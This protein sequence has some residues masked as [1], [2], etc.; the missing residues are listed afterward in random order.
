[1]EKYAQNPD[2]IAIYTWSKHV[3]E[4]ETFKVQS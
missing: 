2:E 4:A 1:M 3:I